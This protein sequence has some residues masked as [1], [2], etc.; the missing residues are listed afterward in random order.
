MLAAREA[1]EAVVTGGS[2]GVT[3]GRSNTGFWSAVLT[4][5]WAIG[6]TVAFAGEAVTSPHR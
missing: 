5:L 1:H 4:T 3:A 6:F 2:K